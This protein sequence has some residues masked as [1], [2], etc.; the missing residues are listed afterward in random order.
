MIRVRLLTW[1][2]IWV[3]CRFPVELHPFPDGISLI[4]D[5]GL[6]LGLGLGFE[7]GVGLW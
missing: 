2:T 5:E 3:L 4:M 6:G 7:L 1:S